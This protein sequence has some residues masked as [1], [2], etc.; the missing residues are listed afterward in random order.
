MILNFKD[1]KPSPIRDVYAPDFEITNNRA[2]IRSKA[3]N[4]YYAGKLE[5]TQVI[6]CTSQTK[7]CTIDIPYKKTGTP[8][9]L[10]AFIQFVDKE[11]KRIQTDYLNNDGE[12][13]H[14][15]LDIPMDCI[16]LTLVLMFGCT[17]EGSVEF[18]APA[19]EF[20]PTKP[21]RTAHIA[22]AFIERKGNEQDNFNQVL[23]LIDEAGNAADKPDVIC[24]TESVYDLRCANKIYISEDSPQVKAVCES[25]RKNSI[26]VLFTTHEKDAQDY[27]YNTAFLISDKGE[28]VG[29]Y[30]K[31]QLT[32]S[33]YL[34]GI[35]PGDE[36]PVFETPFGKIGILICWDQ[37]FYEASRILASKGAE[38]IFWL[39]R[40]FHEER[41]ITRARDNGVYYVTSHP[42]PQNCCII[43]PATGNTIVRGGEEPHGYVSAEIDLDDRPVS[44]YKS[45]GRNG[46]NDKE[47]FLNERRTDLYDC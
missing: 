43:Q 32:M 12:K 33:E 30:R 34:S 24:F 9:R 3:S 13:L 16:R 1:F 2:Q 10:C 28:I 26:Y 31:C 4:G 35:V 21:H 27:Y 46:G 23:E 7:S 19:L 8:T 45:M 11:E 6:E 17:G 42:R 36:L 41:L 39:T 25:A 44:E 40:G 37:W 15:R 5:Y 14:I 29:R 20:T 47:V 22:T 38:I 18:S